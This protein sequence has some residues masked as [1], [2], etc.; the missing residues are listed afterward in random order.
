MNFGIMVLNV[1]YFVCRHSSSLCPFCIFF[2]YNIHKNKLQLALPS[3]SYLW[4]LNDLYLSAFETCTTRTAHEHLSRHYF[5]MLAVIVWE[6]CMCTHL[7]PSWRKLVEELLSR[8]LCLCSL[9][10][11]CF[12]CTFT[13]L[14]S[15][16]FFIMLLFPSPSFAY[17]LSLINASLFL[18]LCLSLSQSCLILAPG[19]AQLLCKPG[20]FFSIRN[21]DFLLYSFCLS[22]AFFPPP[23]ALAAGY[24]SPASS[25][26][27]H[28][29][30]S[31]PGPSP[32][33][34]G[35]CP[36]CPP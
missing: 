19:S 22:P 3:G 5:F 17:L 12:C 8:F 30:H 33:L 27:R 26:V 7:T 31:F 11:S 29:I 24:R 35:G 14:V 18:S 15:T 13:L 4:I 10:R 20:H 1:G 25:S 28:P 36:G 16:F 9:G 32:W 23:V 6:A 34:W 21:P 2:Y